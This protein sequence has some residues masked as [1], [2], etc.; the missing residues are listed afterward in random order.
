MDR[1]LVLCEQWG[2][3]L[4]Q[5]SS[6]CCVPSQGLIRNIWRILGS[7]CTLLTWLIWDV[8]YV[9]KCAPPHNWNKG[10]SVT[11]AKHKLFERWWYLCVHCVTWTLG[12]EKGTCCSEMTGKQRGPSCCGQVMAPLLIVLLSSFALVWY[13]CGGAVGLLLV[14]TS[15]GGATAGMISFHFL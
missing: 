14:R 10:Q 11:R 15:S 3:G 8:C 12:G 13:W 5:V 6:Y 7:G 2:C 1:S 9:A 4:G